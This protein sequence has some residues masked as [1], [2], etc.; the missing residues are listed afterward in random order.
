MEELNDRIG[1]KERILYATSSSKILRVVKSKY[2]K[3]RAPYLRFVE[4]NITKSASATRKLREVTGLY[5]NCFC[6]AILA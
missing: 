2:H 1:V 4:A 6:A 5:S 3:I